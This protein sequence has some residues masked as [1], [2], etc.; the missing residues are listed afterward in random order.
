MQS[1]ISYIEEKF[2]SIVCKVRSFLCFWWYQNDE[3]Q[4]QHDDSGA[5]ILPLGCMRTD[6]HADKEIKETIQV[7][8]QNLM[9]RRSRFQLCIDSSYP[10][11]IYKSRDRAVSRIPAMQLKRIL[12]K[13]RKVRQSVRK[14]TLK[15]VP[16]SSKLHEYLS[17]K[18]NVYQ[19]L[20]Y[21]KFRSTLKCKQS[22]QSVKYS[23]CANQCL[24][25]VFVQIRSPKHKKVPVV[26]YITN[27]T[28]L[29]RLKCFS[30]KALWVSSR[31]VSLSGDIEK[32]PGPTNQYNENRNANCQCLSHPVSLLES[33]LSQI[34]RVAIDVG[35][36]GDCFF[37]A[38]S[39]QL[40]GT[41][42]Y[43]LHV[44]SQGIQYL[45]HNPELF[46]ESNIERSWQDYLSHMSREGTWADGIIIQAVAN[47]LNLTI[48]IAESFENF[49]PLTVIH[50]GNMQRNSTQVYIGHIGEYH[51]VST[52]NLVNLQCNRQEQVANDYTDQ[53]L[54]FAVRSDD[55]QAK[56]K[57][58][59]C[60]KDYIQSKILNT[61]QTEMNNIKRRNTQPI[62]E[63]EQADKITSTCNTV[64]NHSEQAREKQKT[65]K[66]RYI[67]KKRLDTAYTEIENIKRRKTQ[68]IS[69]AEHADKITK[70]NGYMKQLMQGNEKTLILKK[71]KRKEKEAKQK[72]LHVC[73]KKVIQRLLPIQ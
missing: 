54:V 32:N 70:R 35:G 67:Q 64:R 49:S 73:Q 34:G 72:H 52:V 22:K 18:S 15:L 41:P 47:C 2:N 56:T 66:R 50:P 65:R 26:S 13:S 17:R 51:Y 48:N 42:D 23:S 36:A 33:R 68:P 37:R 21:D 40:F 57:Q 12:Q 5:K 62:S 39:H 16:K 43:H 10:R 29:A 20:T 31:I 24:Y 61:A 1:F 3:S 53:Q 30:L 55:E 69:E 58:K 63:A 9:T 59:A 19:R 7:N 11:K 44:R 38:I 6:G 60:E 8:I 25:L 46:I 4:S 28:G 45:L 71:K 27:L 14:H